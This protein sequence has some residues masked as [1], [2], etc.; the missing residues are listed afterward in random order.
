MAESLQNYDSTSTVGTISADGAWVWDGAIWHPT[1]AR[2]GVDSSG[3]EWPAQL[4]ADQMGVT[5][6]SGRTMVQRLVLSLQVFIGTA[7]VV[8][9]GYSLQLVAPSD[10][11]GH[12]TAKDSGLRLVWDFLG[13]IGFLADGASGA[14]GPGRP[15]GQRRLGAGL[16]ARACKALRDLQPGRGRRRHFVPVVPVAAIAAQVTPRGSAAGL[17][18]RDG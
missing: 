1:Y 11:V 3:S 16:R 5:Y 4:P 9:V 12:P 6:D 17:R 18:F 10:F 13:G 14:V 15:G 8:A 2:N 7:V